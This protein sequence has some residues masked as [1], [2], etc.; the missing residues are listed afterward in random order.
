MYYVYKYLRDKDSKNGFIDSPYYIGK[1]KGWRAYG[2]HRIPVP[3][4][5]SRI[6]IVQDGL[7]NKQAM[8]LECLLIKLY[9]RVDLDTGCLRNLTD[10]G[11]GTE[12]C[13]C[14]METRLAIGRAN[15]GRSKPKEFCQTQSLR[16]KGE[17]NPFYGKT[18]DEE[19]R[20][21]ISSRLKGKRKGISFTEEHKRNM[22]K[23]CVGRVPWNKGKTGVQ[24]YSSRNK[25]SLGQWSK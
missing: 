19:T 8:D 24:D 20:K 3:K 5:K 16:M 15:K 11:E 1:G 22:S 4:D 12:G 2:K 21:K 9:G 10:G 25:N 7:T 17:N 14:K 13:I 18:H 23:A 6:V